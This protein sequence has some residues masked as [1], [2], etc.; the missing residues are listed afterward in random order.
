MVEAI[1]VGPDIEDGRRFLD[2][3]NIEGFGVTA[4]LWHKPP[5]GMW[6]FTIVTPLVETEDIR[7]LV[8]RLV[9][10][11]RSA[12]PPLHFTLNEIYTEGP[13]SPFAKHLRR[14]AKGAVNTTVTGYSIEDGSEEGYIYFVK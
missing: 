10:A 5:G 2:I 6:R 8:R 13:K 12:S 7:V 3:L 9:T 14:H 4:A 1:L 11:L